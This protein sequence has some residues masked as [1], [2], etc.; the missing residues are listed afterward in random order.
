MS[1]GWQITLLALG[2]LVIIGVAYYYIFV[3]NATPTAVAT[4]DEN[5]PLPIDPS[6]KVLAN[7]LYRVQ[8]VGMPKE[9]GSTPIGSISIIT[10]IKGTYVV[11]GTTPSEGH[12]ILNA[13]LYRV[14]VNTVVN[15]NDIYQSLPKLE[16]AKV[17]Q[18][19]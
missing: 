18:V 3:K 5:Q 2:T 12:T 13:G 16:S 15:S 7:G 10:L 6:I 4:S 9:G 8:G 11:M 1:K 19:N 14:G 17:Y